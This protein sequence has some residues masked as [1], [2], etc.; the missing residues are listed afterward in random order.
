[1]PKNICWA[2]VRVPEHPRVRFFKKTDH[3]KFEDVTAQVAKLVVEDLQDENGTCML[4]RLDANDQLVWQ[5]K[6]LSLRE[7]K[8]HVEFEYGL[9]E[10]KWQAGEPTK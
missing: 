9:P 5:T 1:M 6:H 7:V 4:R 8:W 3:A 10:E 2:N